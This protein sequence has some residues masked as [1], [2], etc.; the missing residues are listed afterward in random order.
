MELLQLKYFYES[1]NTESF[2]KTAQRHLIP[3]SSVSASIKRLEKEL[4]CKLFDR[5][6]NHIKLNQ[7]GKR[8][9]QSLCVV[10]N[11][12]NTVFEELSTSNTD[13]REIRLL[14]R[15]IRSNITDYIIEYNKKFP[16]ISFKTVFDYEENELENYDI[17]IDEKSNTYSGFDGFLLCNMQ[18]R[19]QVSKESPLLNKKLKLKDLYNQP[20]ISL[21][22]NSNMNKMLISACKQAGFTPNI[23]AQINDIG[24]YEKMIASGIGIGLGREKINSDK[25]STLDVINFD[26]R[27]TVFAYYRPG[28]NYGNIRHFLDFLK[29]K[30]RYKENP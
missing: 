28:E 22:E 24:C 8:L 4:G 7:N 1:A 13:C 27:Y 21:S 3:V 18:I 26:Q 10:F 23:I 30:V 6:S 17:I 12:L 25:I 16:H 15:S 20:F 14:I 11:E 5:T 29:G 19:M 9:Q 2:T